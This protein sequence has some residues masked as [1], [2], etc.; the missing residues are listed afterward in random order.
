MS[1]PV[2]VRLAQAEDI[3]AILALASAA[4]EAPQWQEAAYREYL[5]QPPAELQRRAMWVAE[6]GGSLCGFAAATCVADEAELETIAVA[7][8]ARRSGVGS[9]LL[10]AVEHWAQRGGAHALLLEVRA[11]NHGAQALYLSRKFERGGRR[12]G[13]YSHP[14]ED[15]VLMRL[16]LC[17]HDLAD[18]RTEGGEL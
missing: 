14:V 11:G 10:A 16:K 13:Y 9:R 5:A 7:A 4:A 1:L 3:G 15:A 2:H 6:S 17:E 8:D 18:G 12:A